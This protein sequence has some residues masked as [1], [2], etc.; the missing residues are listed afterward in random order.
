M[1]NNFNNLNNIDAVVLCGGLGTRIKNILG[2]TPKVMA[3]FDD[4]PFLDFHLKKNAVASI[5]VSQVEDAGDFGSIELDDECRITAFR[6]KV[7][8]GGRAGHVN[9]GIYC[10][11]KE[12]FS[13][14]P[15][16]NKFSLECDF[17]PGMINQGIYGFCVEQE[18]LDIGTPQRY[19]KAQKKLKR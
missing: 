3:N 6:E 15:D 12:V 10:F 11:S 18:F 2:D 17:F 13:H 9:A 8:E 5:V 7:E 1:S 14:M 16:E 4:K 19:A